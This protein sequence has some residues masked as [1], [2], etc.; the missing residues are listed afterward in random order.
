MEIQEIKKEIK[1]LK[2]LK[3]QCRAGTKERVDLH[4]QIKELKNK[5]VDTSKPEPEKEL[6]IQEI[7]K[8]KPSYITAQNIDYKKFSVKQLNFHLKKITQKGQ[9]ITIDQ[10]E[11]IGKAGQVEGTKPE[12]ERQPEPEQAIKTRGRGRP[13][14]SRNKK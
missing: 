3:L 6:L 14:G 11:D 5:I 12:P 8:L 7:L 1:R 4:R 13:K 2:R 9:D 10:P